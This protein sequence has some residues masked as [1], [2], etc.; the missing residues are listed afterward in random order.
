MSVLYSF[1]IFFASIIGASTGIGGGVMIKPAL[2]FIGNDSLQM[3][4]LISS[5]AVFVMACYSL[6]DFWKQRKNLKYTMV[7]ILVLGSSLGGYIGQTFFQWIIFRIDPL[8][9]Q[10]F[11]SF[12]M[13]IMLLIV[14]HMVSK[15][16]KTTK[17]IS[18]RGLGWIGLLL[19][20]ISTFLGIG[21]GP[22]NVAVYTYYCAIEFKEARIYSLMTIFFSQLI[23]L[24]KVNQSTEGLML[25]TTMIGWIAI[26]AVLGSMMGKVIY[27]KKSSLQLQKL[28]CMTLYLLIGINLFNLVQMFIVH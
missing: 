7:I 15:P 23:S 5:L 18:K 8:W 2:D 10:G 20:L 3:I 26:C 4:N 28:F 14:I 24:I 17:A 6:M 16:S 12:F 21:G 1:V 9:V 13:M 22:L 27:H 25:S 11:Q 19:G